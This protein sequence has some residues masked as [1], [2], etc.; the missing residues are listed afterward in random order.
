MRSRRPHFGR[1]RVLIACAIALAAA[2]GAFA[3][4]ADL[5]VVNGKVFT[6]DARSSLAEGFAVKGGRFIAVGSSAAMQEHVGPG[7]PWLQPLEI[8]SS[9]SLR[10]SIFGSVGRSANAPTMVFTRRRS[11]SSRQRSKPL[12][13]PSK[14][15][16]GR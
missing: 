9:K 15:A 7:R 16:S 4:T 2:H 3:Q 13:D 10:R 14:I 12:V 1:A 5:V 11:S 8:L 6:A